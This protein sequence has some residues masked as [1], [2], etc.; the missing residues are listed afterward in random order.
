MGCCNYALRG[1]GIVPTEWYKSKPHVGVVWDSI[2][3]CIMMVHSVSTV[4]LL[5]KVACLYSC[6]CSVYKQTILC[7]GGTQR[8]RLPYK[9]VESSLLSSYTFNSK[10]S[11]AIFD[12]DPQ[13]SMINNNMR[14][15]SNQ[16]TMLEQG[17][18]EGS[19][20]FFF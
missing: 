5:V 10:S 15:T 17:I 4:Q 11:M 1:L 16:T 20:H 3:R 7:R 2:D 19:H 14:A 13:R 9:K 8:D 12:G 18:P 6:S